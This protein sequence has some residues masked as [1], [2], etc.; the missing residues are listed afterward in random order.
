MILLVWLQNY[1]HPSQHGFIPGKGTDTAWK[2]IISEVLPAKYIYEIDLKEFFDRVNLDY[3]SN[4]LRKLQIP[5]ELIY[6]L[7]GWSR[8]APAI[9]QPNKIRQDLGKFPR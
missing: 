2:Q 6:N 4:T 8:I 1:Q 9:I 3:L 7:I 5:E